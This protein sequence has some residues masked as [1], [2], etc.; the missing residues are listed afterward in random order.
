LGGDRGAEV[1][2]KGSES[3]RQRRRRDGRLPR[4]T[5]V[6]GSVAVPKGFSPSGRALPTARRS[7]MKPRHRNAPQ[8]LASQYA[9]AASLP[10]PVRVCEIEVKDPSHEHEGIDACTAVGVRRG[11]SR[12]ARVCAGSGMD[13]GG[14]HRSAFSRVLSGLSVPQGR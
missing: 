10:L 8:D 6:R 12:S 4:R 11:T 13:R 14:N 1:V 7:L 3:D 9:C 2:G 5:A